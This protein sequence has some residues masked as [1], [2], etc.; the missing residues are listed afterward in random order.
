MGHPYLHV[1][2]SAHLSSRCK[3]LVFYYTPTKVFLKVFSAQPIHTAELSQR[4]LNLLLLVVL[5]EGQLAGF[6]GGD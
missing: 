4:D 1:L 3:L 2:R 6:A 5:P